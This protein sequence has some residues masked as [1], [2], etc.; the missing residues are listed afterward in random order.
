MIWNNK[1]T[2]LIFVCRLN[3]TKEPEPS[4][5]QSTAA[6]AGS[7]ATTTIS[8]GEVSGGKHV[9]AQHSTVS[10]TSSTATQML[11]KGKS[12]NDSSKL[13]HDVQKGK[14]GDHAVHHSVLKKKKDDQD[15]S[16]DKAH[17]S[18]NKPS[19]HATQTTSGGSTMQH[20]MVVSTS[21]GSSH[22]GM[23]KPLSK[24]H[25]QQK[26]VLQSIKNIPT[27]S[28]TSKIDKQ[29]SATFIFVGVIHWTKCSMF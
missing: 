15:D 18:Q 6:S 11:A 27:S 24:S 26:K 5:K 9:S 28:H 7:A 23:Q 4:K 1:S 21:S 3:I 13:K 17:S 16:G 14:S 25:D 2:S 8:T 20:H 19:G 29:V 22:S 10:T 12:A